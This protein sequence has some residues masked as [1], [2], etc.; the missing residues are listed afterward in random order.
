M[1][2]EE[3]KAFAEKHGLSFIE[4]SA[5]DSTNV[6]E[7]FV[8]ILTGKI[9]PQSVSHFALLAVRKAN[10]TN[11]G[12][13]PFAFMYVSYNLPEIYR[14]VSQKQITDGPGDDTPRGLNTI[15]VEPTQDSSMDYRKRQC[16]SGGPLPL[17]SD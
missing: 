7:A 16:C 1:P 11:I 3:A 13:L 15:T 6:E 12:S 10:S 4:T 5:L 17:S 8:N 14:I 9:P 2:P